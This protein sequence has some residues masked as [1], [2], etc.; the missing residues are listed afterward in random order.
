MASRVPE[1]HPDI[2]PPS[3]RILCLSGGGYRGLFSA[4]VL[5]HVEAR[6][7]RLG[8]A[9]L[10]DYFHL[11]AGTSI[12]GLLACGIAAGISA[13]R[14]REALE[15]NGSTVFPE[16]SFAKARQ[17][18]GSLYS[19]DALQRVVSKCLGSAANSTLQKIDV[20]LLVPAV[21]WITGEVVLY[22]SAGLAK[23]LAPDVSL[24][25]VCLATSAAPTYFP[26]HQLKKA[27][28][29][30]DVL[31]DGG[32]VA[33]APDLAAL[34][35]AIQ[36]WSL[37]LNRFEVMS[38]GTAGSAAGGVAA[39]VPTSGAGW[40]SR[41]KIVTLVLSA[42]ERHAVTNCRT[43]L[44]DR[45]FRI[46]QQP[47]QGHLELQAMDRVDVSTTATLRKLAEHALQIAQ[48]SA[49]TWASQLV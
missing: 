30:S 35:A 28:Q 48:Q 12:G 45:Y 36:R 15:E 33:N 22:K 23:S 37:P 39:S 1:G 47:S 44:G 8:H 42:Q 18:I 27:G 17:M 34:T 29:L 19:A 40:A 10:R 43:L 32:L 16:R 13:Q 14:L 2:P 7:Q 38:I 21:S 6:L 20:P 4:I 26:A 41:A 9:L 11:V 25:D 5:E 24:L 31:V 49:P 3:R 46:D